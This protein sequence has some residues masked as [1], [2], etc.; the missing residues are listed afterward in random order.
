MDVEDSR[1]EWKEA[2]APFYRVATIHIPAQVFDTPAQSQFC[3]N[4]SFTPWHALPEHKPFGVTNRLRKV[5]YDHMSRLRQE[6]NATKRQEPPS[7]D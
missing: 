7:P 1:T 6:M 5:I 3:E 4:L 2:Q